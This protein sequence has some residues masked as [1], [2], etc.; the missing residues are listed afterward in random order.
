MKHINYL[1]VPAEEVTEA[2]AHGVKIQWLITE[3]DGA[4]NF[5]MRMIVFTPGGESPNH[6]HA[7]EHEVFIVKGHGTVQVD[8]KTI[9]LNAGDVV[10][11]PPNI[12][13]HFKADEP[14]EML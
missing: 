5:A 7:S 1:N 6:S 13:H 12:K 9:I 14:M 10:Y 11:I 2:G 4:P 8:E 3:K